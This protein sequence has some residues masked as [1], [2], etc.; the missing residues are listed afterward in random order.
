MCYVVVGINDNFMI[1]QIVVIYWVIDNEMIGWVDEEFGGR[2]QL[3]SGQNWFDDFF[4][5]CFLQ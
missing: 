3:F 4:Y 5:Y 1:S 2:S